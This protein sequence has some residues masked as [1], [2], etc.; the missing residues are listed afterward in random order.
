[1][2]GNIVSIKDNLPTDL[3]DIFGDDVNS[4]FDGG[5]TSGF[6]IM[7]FRGSKWRVKHGGEEEPVVNDDGDPKP[8]IEVVMLAA[9]EHVS[10]VYYAKAYEEGDDANPDC[11]SVNGITPDEGVP[12][13]QAKRCAV[14]PNSQWGSRVTEAGKKVKACQD[15]KRLAIVP[16]DDLSNESLGG[17]MLLRIPAASLQDLKMHVAKVRGGGHQMNRIATKIGFDMNASYPKLTFKPHRPLKEEELYALVPH[18]KNGS[19]DNVLNSTGDFS[20]AVKEEVEEV[21]E[22]THIEKQPKKQKPVKAK[23]DSMFEAED[24]D[25]DEAPPPKPKSTRSKRGKAAAASKTPDEEDET[26]AKADNAD[27]AGDLDDI[28]SDLDNNG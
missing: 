15:S 16:L 9:N 10:K 28:L 21:E 18:F 23:A 3:A 22:D 2:A 7:S 11:M 5:I 13:P 4:A 20:S 14:C 19:I 24:E 6:A 17:P 25:E 26:P 1:M 8:T 12:N 27:L